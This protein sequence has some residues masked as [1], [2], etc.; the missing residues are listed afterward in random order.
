M[1]RV[2]IVIFHSVHV[3][4]PAKDYG[5]YAITPLQILIDVPPR[6]LFSGIAIFPA[7]LLECWSRMSYLILFLFHLLS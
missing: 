6:Q 7:D 1:H 5:F 2:V 3:G 4:L